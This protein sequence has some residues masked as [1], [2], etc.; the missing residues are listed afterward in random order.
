MHTIHHATRNA[1][2]S[3]SKGLVGVFGN[4]C[5]KYVGDCITFH[6]EKNSFPL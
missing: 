2:L 6:W 4:K 5:D 1:R 3:P